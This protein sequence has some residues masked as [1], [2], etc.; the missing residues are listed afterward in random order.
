M[1]SRRRTRLRAASVRERSGQEERRSPAIGTVKSTRR[2]AISSDANATVVRFRWCPAF[3]RYALILFLVLAA[4]ILITEHSETAGSL[5]TS[6]ELT[7]AAMV[8]VLLLIVAINSTEARVTKDEVQLRYT[9]AAIFPVRTLPRSEIV[10][11]H[12]WTQLRNGVCYRVAIRL[13]FPVYVGTFATRE[14]AL[15]AAQAIAARL[16]VDCR[17]ALPKWKFDFFY[18]LY[19]GRLLAVLAAPLLALLILELFQ[20]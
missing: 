12:H 11:V 15:Q 14:E 6:I 18:L 20:S 3:S 19:L 17:E 5:R 13:A 16:G 9:P 7:W 2:L 10:A 8:L 4:I 1:R